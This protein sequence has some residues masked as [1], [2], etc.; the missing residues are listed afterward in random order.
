MSNTFEKTFVVAI[1]GATGVLLGLRVLKYLLQNPFRIY[2]IISN[3]AYCVL[4]HETGFDG[5]DVNAFLNYRMGH[6]TGCSLVC[7]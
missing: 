4:K 5:G 7:M 6:P 3:A 1:C 2:L